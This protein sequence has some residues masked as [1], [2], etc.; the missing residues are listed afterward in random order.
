MTRAPLRQLVVGLLALPL[1]LLPFIAYCTLTPEGRLVRDK[2]VAWVAPPDLPRLSDAEQRE[3]AAIVPTYGGGVTALVYH[4]LGSS[5]DGEGGYVMTAA[6]FGEHLASL[7][8]AGM[9][10]V[11]AA[12]IAWSMATG[13][14]LPER[15]V[16]ISF[17]D[18]RS[19]ALLWADPLLKQAGMKATM[20]VISETAAKPSLYYAGWDRL[21]AAARSGRWDIEA[22]SHEAHRLQRVESGEDLPALTSLAPGESLAEYQA[23]VHEDLERNS[24][25]IQAH[26][27][28]RP[29]AFA[30]PFGAYGAE[31]ANDPRI[32]EILRNEIANRFVVAFHQ[33]GQDTVPLVNPSQSRIGLRRLSIGN[34]SG[35]D[36]LRRIAKVVADSAPAGPL[37]ESDPVTK[38]LP[39]IPFVPELEKRPGPSVVAAPGTTT[40]VAP[41]TTTTTTVLPPGTTA[42]PTTGPSTTT[43]TSP[44]TT[45]TTGPSSTTTTRPPPTT[46]ST[47]RPPTTTTTSPPPPSTT[48]T[49]RPCHDNRD[50]CKR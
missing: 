27:G 10:V 3:A 16:M 21:R 36:L 2:V 40:T 7:K 34:W 18:G 44:P 30:Y 31:R 22:H 17:D 33:D 5:S 12:D 46:T 38:S 19:D 11:T 32:Q 47:T 43:A 15:A 9:Q 48:T 28:Q 25:A 50:S 20:F 35:T 23:R 14:P 37:A 26:I 41:A 29:V 49:T 13:T 39:P 24:A 6:R 4:G 1:S 42:P 8:A 45:R